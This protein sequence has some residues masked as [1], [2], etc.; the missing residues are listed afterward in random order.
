ML[1][2]YCEGMR[3][4]RY[5]L[6]ISLLCA[7]GVR[8]QEPL[9][10]TSRIE[11]SNV[12]GR[13]D[14]FSADVKGKRLFISALGNHTVE[15]LDVDSGKRLRTLTDLAEPQGACYDPSTNRLSVACAKDGD[16]KL[17]DAGTFQ[18][19]NTTEFS[20]DADNIRYDARGGSRG[21]YGQTG[22]TAC[23]TT[24]NRRS[25]RPVGQAFSLSG[26]DRARRKRRIRSDKNTRPLPRVN[27]V[28]GSGVIVIDG[29]PRFELKLSV[30]PSGSRLVS[31]M[32]GSMWAV[33]IV[34]IDEFAVAFADANILTA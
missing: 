34:V 22:G 30:V 25:Q 20:A 3:A 2:L 15:V 11:L 16:V 8:G 14:H 21:A 32:T 7:A 27:W 1:H 29:A 10:L 17:F 19:L 6:A 28:V 23:P 13:A 9:S 31:V 18:L 5:P 12:D 24:Q 26:L 33:E 4:I